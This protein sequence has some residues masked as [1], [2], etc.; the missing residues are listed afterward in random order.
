MSSASRLQNVNIV[1]NNYSRYGTSV[2]DKLYHN[3]GSGSNNAGKNSTT[4]G[5][6]S[7]ISQK[8]R[9]KQRHGSNCSRSMSQSPLSTFK[10]PLSNQNQSSAPDDLASIG[11]R[12]SDDVTSLDNETIITMNSRKSRIKKKYKSL[13]STS[14]KNL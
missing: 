12:R 13:I 11:Q 10:S 5:K 7:S 6:L 8:S 1:S 3:N 9:S 2:Y 4:V 14:S